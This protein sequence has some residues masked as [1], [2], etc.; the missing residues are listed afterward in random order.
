MMRLYVRN[1]IK[2]DPLNAGKSLI[3]VDLP[4]PRSFSVGQVKEEFKRKATAAKVDSLYFRQLDGSYEVLADDRT[5]GFYNIQDNAVLETTSN[6]LWAAAIYYRLREVERDAANHPDDGKSQRGIEQS[7]IQK[8]MALGILFNGGKNQERQQ[9]P[10]F[11]ELDQLYEYL[12]TAGK[13]PVH[14]SQKTLETLQLL[15][16]EYE[17][18]DVHEQDSVGHFVDRQAVKL[19]LKSKPDAKSDGHYSSCKGTGRT[20]G[21]RSRAPALGTAGNNKACD[22]S[23]RQRETRNTKIGKRAPQKQRTCEDCEVNL[24]TQFCSDCQPPLVLCD[25]CAVVL[26]RGVTRRNHQLK[27]VSFAPTPARSKGYTPKAYRAPFALLVAFH[28]AS[29]EVPKKMSL[30][31]DEL[32]LRAQPLTN[33]DLEIKQGRWFGGFDSLENTLVKNQLVLKEAKTPKYSLMEKGQHL[34]ARCSE[35]DYAFQNL[36]QASS[37]P[38]IPVVRLRP[39]LENRQVCLLVDSEEP[40]R[41]RFVRVAGQKG[42][43]AKTRKL[44]VGDFLW[45]LL[46][47]G[48]NPDTAR[49]IP[50][51]ELVLPMVVERKTWDDLWSSLKTTRFVNQ[52][53]RMKRCGLKNLFYLVE[54]SP[55]EIKGNPGPDVESYLQDKIDTLLLVENFLVNRTGSW[56]KTVEWLCHLTSMTTEF[57]QSDGWSNLMTFSEFSRRSRSKTGFETAGYVATADCTVWSSLEFTDF[58]RSHSRGGRELHDLPVCGAEERSLIVIQGLTF[59]NKQC[60]KLLDKALADLLEN[61]HEKAEACVQR[62]LQCDTDQLIHEDVMQWYILWL[63]VFKG[64]MVRRT[65]SEEESADILCKFSQKFP[66]EA[67]VPPHKHFEAGGLNREASDH[68]KRLPDDDLIFASD[69][70][71]EDAMIRQALKASEYEG[72]NP[73]TKE[74][75]DVPCVEPSSRTSTKTVPPSSSHGGSHKIPLSDMN[76][77]EQLELALELSKVE[78]TPSK[79]L[80]LGSYPHANPTSNLDM[81]TSSRSEVCSTKIEAGGT[82]DELEKALKLSLEEFKSGKHTQN[83]THNHDDTGDDLDRALKLSKIEYELSK[84]KSRVVETCDGDTVVQRVLNLSKL[85]SEMEGREGRCDISIPPLSKAGTAAT[86]SSKERQNRNMD[87]LFPFEDDMERALKRSKLEYEQQASLN[88]RGR[89]G[90]LVPTEKERGAL[91][92]EIQD[93]NEDVTKN[94]RL[95][96]D[97]SWHGSELEEVLELSRIEQSHE[98]SGVKKKDEHLDPDVTCLEDCES[99]LLPR[100]RIISHQNQSI[101]SP[102][103]DTY[104][105]SSVSF[106]QEWDIESGNCDIGVF[107]AIDPTTIGRSKDSAILIDSQELVD[108][109]ANDFNYALKVQEELNRELNNGSSNAHADL[110]TTMATTGTDLKKQLA[111]YRDLQKEKYRRKDKPSPGLDFRRNVAAIACG[112]PANTS[113][114]CSRDDAEG[115]KFAG[116]SSKSPLKNSY[117]KSNVTHSGAASSTN[118]SF[119]S[120]VFERVHKLHSSHL[121]SG[122][123]SPVPGSSSS[124]PSKFGRSESDRPVGPKCGACG[125]IGHNKNSKICP[126]YFSA[127][128]VQRREEQSRKRKAK[129]EEEEREFNDRLGAMAAQRLSVEE[130]TRILGEQLDQ[131][132]RQSQSMADTQKKVEDAIKRRKKQ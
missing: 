111:G 41:E 12:Q 18:N 31:A 124:S 105:P 93:S 45:V 32:K 36:C 54:G 60:H 52:V 24:A 120:S 115:C 55:K 122:S 3:Y 38:T 17:Q 96:G 61:T 121:D 27:D 20:T 15:K 63:Q 109:S 97:K 1:K 113:K 74:V 44:P 79:S 16:D 42:L 73:S 81:V 64:V 128:A 72:Q 71:E 89:N 70:Q 117:D 4:D 132:R 13:K 104:V 82:D 65:E 23:G 102:N 103:N 25:E 101:S 28:R 110:S 51:Q 95:S 98:C 78:S 11:E 118:G 68:W 76:E 90:Q 59:Y 19:G 129:R 69:S 67:V 114:S 123:F 92:S 94:V 53:T 37:V 125:E 21:H 116:L 26:H 9:P 119:P 48:A 86:Q 88:N 5:V 8:Y 14:M 33:S 77:R 2:Y 58:I 62:K 85:E 6:P 34:G 22:D 50:D 39:V 75:F 99:T 106:D 91:N 56:M 130:Q 40:L 107:D 57:L 87:T 108:D 84:E 80:Q 46:P 83:F 131:L 127:E 49:D 29:N 30:T 112:K 35:F 43:A 10:Y 100:G 126:Q 47:P 7:F 66:D